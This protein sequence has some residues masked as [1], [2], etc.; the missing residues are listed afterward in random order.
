MQ[1]Y[2]LI[3]YEK[4]LIQTSNQMKLTYKQMKLIGTTT[5]VPSEDYIKLLAMSN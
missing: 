4:M 3:S 2:S 5:V 1:T